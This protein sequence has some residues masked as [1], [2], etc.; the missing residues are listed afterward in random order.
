MAVDVAAATALIP[1]LDAAVEIPI[2]IPAVVVVVPAIRA[3]AAV[4]L[5]LSI[6]IWDA[7]EAVAAP[8]Q[9]SLM[10]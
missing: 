10:N 1:I 5:R 8:K 9:L 4:V 7:A 6:W 3:A 2:P